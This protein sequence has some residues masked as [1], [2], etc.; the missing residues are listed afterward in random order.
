[1]IEDKLNTLNRIIFVN[2]G[3]FF[4]N[5]MALMLGAV[6]GG[7]TVT[8]FHP[9]FLKRFESWRY[10]IVVFFMIAFSFF[11]SDLSK[12]WLMLLAAVF[13]LTVIKVTKKYVNDYYYA[14]DRAD[15]YILNK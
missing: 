13:F 8:D 1:M 9:S 14:K 3:T 5:I 12:W 4:I 11:D 2:R 15:E 7:Y 6:F 10:Q